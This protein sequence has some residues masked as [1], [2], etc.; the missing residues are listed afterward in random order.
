M[1]GGEIITLLS[2]DKSNILRTST[3]SELNYCF[4]HEKIKFIS[5]NYCVCVFF[6]FVCLFVF[7]KLYEQEYI[8]RHF[9]W[10]LAQT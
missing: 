6:L 2:S 5:L 10:L 3:A 4:W 8:V 1:L 9:H 7:F